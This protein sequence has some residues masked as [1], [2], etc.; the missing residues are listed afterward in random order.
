MSS[1][2]T[3]P[4]CQRLILRPGAYCKPACSAKYKTNEQIKATRWVPAAL[5]TLRGIVQARGDTKL[6]V[7]DPG[8]RAQ[9]STVLNVAIPRCSSRVIS[10][11]LVRLGAALVPAA[12]EPLKGGIAACGN[13]FFFFFFTLPLCPC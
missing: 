11:L 13:P 6:D 12:R 4:A 2:H 3:A 1:P 5:D 9:Y 7:R 10:R 8:L